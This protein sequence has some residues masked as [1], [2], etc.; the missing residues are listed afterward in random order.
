MTKGKVLTQVKSTKFAE[1]KGDTLLTPCT[2]VG[3][4]ETFRS[5]ARDVPGYLEAVGNK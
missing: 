5:C 1:L 3:Q 2:R 4:R